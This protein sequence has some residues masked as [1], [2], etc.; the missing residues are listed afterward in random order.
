MS[1]VR[2]AKQG[3]ILTA[4]FTLISVAYVMPIIIVIWNSFKRKIIID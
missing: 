3:G 4:I 1:N 2:K